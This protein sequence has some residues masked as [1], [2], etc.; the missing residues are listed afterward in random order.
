MGR[1]LCSA[2]EG[3]DSSRWVYKD[4]HNTSYIQ[5]A[6]GRLGHALLVQQYYLSLSKVT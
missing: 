2:E 3:L 1:K 6:S 5:L 4:L